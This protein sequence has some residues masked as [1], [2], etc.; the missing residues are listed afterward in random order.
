MLVQKE[1][2]NVI[3]NLFTKAQQ[4]TIEK[5]LTI[6]TRKNVPYWGA[7]FPNPD[8]GGEIYLN[9]LDPRPTQTLIHELTHYYVHSILKNK[10]YKDGDKPFEQQLEFV[11]ANGKFK[12]LKKP[13]RPEK[14]EEEE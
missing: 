9:S 5:T 2:D 1:I 4:T 13:S 12:A 7:F 8:G 6:K 11:Q 10:S 3:A 14:V